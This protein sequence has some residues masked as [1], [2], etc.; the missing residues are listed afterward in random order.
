MVTKGMKEFMETHV[1]C[2][3]NYE[4]CTVHFVGSI[5]FFFEHELRQ[6]AADLNITLGAIIRKPIDGLV[7]YHIRQGHLELQVDVAG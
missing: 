1:C 7:D 5:G 3:P 2:Y 4:E 6:A